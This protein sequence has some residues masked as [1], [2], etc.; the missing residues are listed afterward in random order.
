M[1]LLTFLAGL[2]QRFL[3][4]LNFLGELYEVM[5]YGITFLTAFLSGA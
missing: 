2:P 3:E 5:V 1:A 4:L